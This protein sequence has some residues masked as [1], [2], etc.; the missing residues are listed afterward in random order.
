MNRTIRMVALD[1]DGTLLNSRKELTEYTKDILRRTVEKG[2][3][4]LPSTGRPYSAL[5]EELKHF[6]GMKYAVTANGARVLDLEEKKVLYEDLLPL[7]LSEKVLKILKKYDA[8]HEF[9]VEGVGYTSVDS[10]ETAYEYFDSSHMAE[11]YMKTR[12]S[13]KDV[14][15]RMKEIHAP[16]DKLQGIFKSIEERAMAIEEIE[17]LP[18]VTVTTAF[19]NN[20]EINKA[21]AD[22]GVGL[23]KL[24]ELLGILPEEIM[25]CGDG[26]NDMSMMQRAG[27]A[28]AMDNSAPQVKEIADYVTG[29]NDED[30]AAK[31]IEELLLGEQ[32]GKIC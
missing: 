3:I 32:E 30:G 6:P 5:P 9:F 25:V 10:L 26:M 28:V 29:N 23:L 13:V 7:D 8:I 31:A 2:I 4:V 16:T 21:G 22:K 27:L 20:I 17:K 19:R 14:E 1:L 24:G 12:Y 18:G 15:A 11:Y